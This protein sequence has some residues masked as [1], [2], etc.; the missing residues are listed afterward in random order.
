M[1]VTKDKSEATASL[2]AAATAEQQEV[3]SISEETR[4]AKKTSGLVSSARR[5]LNK[6]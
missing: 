3:Q 6:Q 2:E 5:I 1:Y 4:S